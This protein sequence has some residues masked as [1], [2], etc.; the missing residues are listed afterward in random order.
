L[1]LEYALGRER[2]NFVAIPLDPFDVAMRRVGFQP[3]D[4]S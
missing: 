2:L 3:V 4:M 1:T